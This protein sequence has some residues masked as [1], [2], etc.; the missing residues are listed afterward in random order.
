MGFTSF[1]NVSPKKPSHFYVAAAAMEYNNIVTKEIESQLREIEFSYADDELILAMV[2]D[3]R[4]KLYLGYLQTASAMLYYLREN[5][6]FTLPNKDDMEE[7][8]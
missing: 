6:L 8:L 5:F 7:V 4:E 1:K 2:D 3:I